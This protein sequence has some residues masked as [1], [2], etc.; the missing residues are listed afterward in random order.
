MFGLFK[1]RD[2]ETDLLRA[3]DQRDVTELGGA[4]RRHGPDA[5]DRDGRTALINAAQRNDLVA[6]GIALD[7]GCAVDAVDKQGLTSLHFAVIASSLPMV[8]LLLRAGAAV[9]PRDGWGNTPLN[10][11]VPLPQQSDAEALVSRLVAA[12]A[13][14]GIANHS[15]VY[16]A[17]WVD[18]DPRLATLL[19]R[20]T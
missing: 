8:E 10:R 15:G 3:L 16:P 17:S 1:G 6:A 9:D 4:I 13:D 20:S 14:P 18:S 12:G 5:V 19:R 11:A 2:F 7:A